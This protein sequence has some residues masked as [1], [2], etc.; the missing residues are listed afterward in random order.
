MD[1]FLRL[2][3]KFN[4]HKIKL[5]YRSLG[6]MAMY[7]IGFFVVTSFIWINFFPS[8]SESRYQ[9]M[10]MKNYKAV[11]IEISERLKKNPADADLWRLLV[12]LRVMAEKQ[13]QK[14]DVSNMNPLNPEDAF[15]GSQEYLFSESEFLNFLETA[16][17]PEP[18]LLKLRYELYKSHSLKEIKYHNKSLNELNEIGLILMDAR[19][20]KEAIEVFYIVL[21]SKPEDTEAKKHIFKCLTYSM[22]VNE[23]KK[24]IEDPAWR[25]FASHYD[26]YRYHLEKHSFGKMLYHLTASEYNRYSWKAIVACSV[27]GLGWILFLTH[28]G[29]GWFWKR[30]EQLL[31]PLAVTLGFFSTI[32]CL[33]VVVVQDHFLQYTGMKADNMIYNLGYCVLGIGLREELCKMLFF[34][35]L[36]F[37]LKNIREEYK[38]LCYCSLVGLGFAIEEN[39]SYFM[40]YGNQVL[41][42]R[43]LTANFLHMFTTG[44]VCFY[45]V[46]AIQQKGK[47]WDEFTMTFLK[48]VGIHGIYDFL[49]MDPNLASKGFGFFAMMLYV[50]VAMMYLRLLMTTAPPAHQYVSLTRVF[51]I[52][53]CLTLGITFLMSSSEIG[54]KLTIK[55]IFA[56]VLG[57]AIFAYMFYREINEPIG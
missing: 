38:L 30:K 34:L 26:L 39:L 57:N 9:I 29:S 55:I 47:A 22:Q 35:P 5:T 12:Q 43:F 31:I 20:F 52:A 23:V 33:G 11:E 7:I 54:I 45:L 3:R 40:N 18:K 8:N 24:L 50:Y 13:P 1:T 53:L 2:R 46:K 21:D 49:L 42:T 28:L 48:M 37:F 6:R 44:F 14:L 32:F 15:G 36:L 25:P 17:K 51:T 10:A 19:M 4:F 16:E 56:G 27:T 41:M